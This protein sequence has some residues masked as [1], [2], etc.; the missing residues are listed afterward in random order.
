MIAF[1]RRLTVIL[2]MSACG[3]G[4][5]PAGS[6]AGTDAAFC[7]DR[8]GPTVLACTGAVKTQCQAWAQTLVR[9]GTAHASCGE[10]APSCLSGDACFTSSQ[11][12]TLC[13]CAGVY[14][15]SDVCVTPPE[16]GSPKCVKPCSQ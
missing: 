4:G 2:L 8:V 7:T 3:S 6:D 13:T 12:I 5:A 11:G 15:G 1:V 9:S 16:G 14:C 10:R